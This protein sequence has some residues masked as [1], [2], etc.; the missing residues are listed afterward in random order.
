MLVV[1]HNL[2]AM[3]ANKQLNITTDKKA[4]NTEKLSSGYRIN[5]AA[6]DAAGLSI[7]EKLRFQVRGLEKASQNILDG[8]GYVQ[9]GEGALNEV[10]AMLNRIKELA[11]QASNDTNTESDR[12]QIDREIQE[13]KKETKRIFNDTEFNTIKIFR[14]PYLPDISSMPDDFKIF[15]DGSASNMGGVLINNKRYTWDEL[16]LPADHGDWEKKFTDDNG[17]LIYLKLDAGQDRSQIR[18]EYQ[19]DADGSGIYIN[20]LRA[21]NWSD[22]TKSDG[23]I[24]F[25]F[26]KM[27][28]TIDV[29]DPDNQEDLVAHLKKD[30]ISVISWDAYPMSTTGHSAV[31]SAADNMVLNVTDSNKNSIENTSF[32]IKADNTNVWVEQNVGGT[33]TAGTAKSWRSFT[34]LNGHGYSIT[35]FGATNDTAHNVTDNP[36]GNPVT[37][38]DDARYNFTDTTNWDGRT[39]NPNDTLGFDF[40]FVTDEVSLAEAAKGISQS[41][42]GSSVS[43][44]INNITTNNSNVTSTSN[45][46]S[47]HFQRDKLDRV[48]GSDGTAVTPMQITVEREKNVTGYVTDYEQRKELTQLYE[49]ESQLYYKDK[50]GQEQQYNGETCYELD[51]DPSNARDTDGR[52]YKEAT[53]APDA[54]K[55]VSIDSQYVENKIYEVCSYKYT[56]NK[57]GN[58]ILTA[59]SGPFVNT[60]TDIKDATDGTVSTASGSQTFTYTKADGSLG[61][62]Y[63]NKTNLAIRSITLSDGGSNSITLRYDD[64]S[65]TG[66]SANDSV[67]V[68]INPKGSATRTYTKVRNDG[69][70]ASS[71][72]NLNIKINPPEKLV[73]I[74][75]GALAFQNIDIRYSALSNTIV[76]ISGINTLTYGDSQNAMQMADDAIDF[77]STVR[78]GFGAQQNRLEHAYAADQNTRENTDAAESR[79]RDTDMAKEMVNDSKHSILEQAGQ[80]M[81]AQANQNKQGILQLLT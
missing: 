21:A 52:R 58:P 77:I 38:D 80:S 18:R 20:N 35:D 16:G 47:F 30:N 65:D 4:K 54:T 43:A 72:T 40:N 11:T 46:L 33:K 28:I 67:G 13:I 5:R 81:L 63:N 56:V 45:S 32:S 53:G 50:N 70:G 1:Q 61:T 66:N 78:S 8:V 17:E 6:D 71:T 10:H 62:E 76:G 14:A 74:Q 24:N 44:P 25:E 34:D 69:S 37:L 60:T 31:Q 57:G 15:N 9:T 59:S 73:H 29:D 39:N 27:N 7:S 49:R 12:D 19:M 64:R 2:E 79:I 41:L 55:Y 68:T 48:F 42:S 22:I 75:S 3:F 23:S 26:H 36:N 51:D